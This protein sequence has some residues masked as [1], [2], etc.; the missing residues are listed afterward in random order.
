MEDS[1]FDADGK[2]ICTLFLISLR[3]VL[4]ALNYLR[5]LNAALRICV[6]RCGFHGAIKESG[7]P[8]VF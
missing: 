3:T 4:H 2:K 7:C 8:L 5:F 1:C 6:L